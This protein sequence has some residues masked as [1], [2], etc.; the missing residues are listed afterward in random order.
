MIIESDIGHWNVQGVPTLMRGTIVAPSCC[1]GS[2]W[3]AT[4]A[5]LISS[6]RSGTSANGQR[7]CGGA[8]F[9]DRRI[10]TIVHD[11]FGPW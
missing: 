8:P 6:G 2:G 5:R 7:W 11:V 4:W 10:E 3:D 9:D 1:S